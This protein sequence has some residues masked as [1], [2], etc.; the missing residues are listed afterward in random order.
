MYFC[1]DEGNEVILSKPLLESLKIRESS[2]YFKNSEKVSKK[3]HFD[4]KSSSNKNIKTS[5]N[6]MGRILQIVLG[7]FQ[8]SSCYDTQKYRNIFQLSSRP[9]RSDLI[10]RTVAKADKYH[11]QPLLRAGCLNWFYELYVRINES[12]KKLG[13]SLGNI[14]IV[15]KR[16]TLV[17]IAAFFDVI[18][19]LAVFADLAL[20]VLLDLQ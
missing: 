3:R 14:I 11:T 18:Y 17:F 5:F 10:S 19:P 15:N 13:L 9:K 8:R 16:A 1:F 2:Q 4:T 7:Q 6:I 12:N 20:L